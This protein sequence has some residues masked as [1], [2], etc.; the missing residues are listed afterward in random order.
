M[1]RGPDL[2]GSVNRKLV[3]GDPSAWKYD[4]D[5]KTGVYIIKGKQ[6]IVGDELLID[7]GTT[8]KVLDRILMIRPHPLL[9]KLGLVS[10]QEIYDEADGDFVPSVRVS[11]DEPLNGE[12]ELPWYFK[13]YLGE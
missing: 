4:T 3:F 2:R 9:Y 1:I 12:L 7:A 6:L 8:V 5:F 11:L 10:C 13:L